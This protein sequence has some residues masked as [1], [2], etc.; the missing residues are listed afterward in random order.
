QGSGFLYGQI[1]YLP[2][3]L[4][5]V[6]NFIPFFSVLSMILFGTGIFLEEKRKLGM[7]LV[8]SSLFLMIVSIVIFVVGLSIFSDVSVG[9]IVGKGAIELDVV[10]TE[11]INKIDSMWGLSTGFYLYVVSIISMLLGFVIRFYPEYIWRLL[12]K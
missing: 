3:L 6:F 8:F 4:V 11:G 12:K 1:D 7:A 10:G 5:S 2:E 9:G